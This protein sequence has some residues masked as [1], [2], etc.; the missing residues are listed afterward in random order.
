MYFWTNTPDQIKFI[1]DAADVNRLNAYINDP[2]ITEEQAQEYQDQFAL[3]K[4]AM[5]ADFTTVNE[6]WEDWIIQQGFGPP[7]MQKNGTINVP[8][9]GQQ[10]ILLN[11]PVLEEATAANGQTYFWQDFFRMM[12]LRAFMLRSTFGGEKGSYHP[13]EYFRD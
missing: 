8:D 12:S 6:A 9:N 1:S 3:A 5:Y 2:N 4:F 11:L 13:E 10:K 7:Q